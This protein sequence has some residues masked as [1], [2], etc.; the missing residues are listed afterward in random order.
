MKSIKL[1]LFIIAMTVLVFLFGVFIGQ[2]GCYYNAQLFDF[3]TE[4]LWGH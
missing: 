1:T 4:T 3:R 2:Q